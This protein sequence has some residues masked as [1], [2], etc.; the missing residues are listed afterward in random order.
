MKKHSTSTT[1]RAAL[2]ALFFTISVGLVVLAVNS[3]ILNDGA[4]GTLRAQGTS[5]SAPS[6][7]AAIPI[8]PKDTG[9][10]IGYENF[11][12]PGVLTPVKTTEAGQQVNSVEYLGRNAGE[13]SVGSNWATGV[14]NF[15][16]GLQT[17]FIT[18]DDSCPLT[19][20][21][22]N[23][24]NRAAPT[25]IAIDSDPIGFTDRGFTDALGAHSRVFAGELTLLS[26]NTVKIS[27]TDDDG[28]TWV[29]DQSGGI[30]S[31]V[32]HETIGGGAYH[33]L[34]PPRPPG[35]TYPNA[36]YYCSQD[37]ATALCARSDDGGLHYGPSVPI[38]SLVDCAG[39]HGHVKVAP[40]GTVYVP[41]R[42]C[43]TPSTSAVVVSQD[44]GVTWT[45]RPVG[46]ASVPSTP[47]SDDPA[48]GID[49]NGRVYFLFSYN[50]TVAGVATSDDFG[51]TWQ[52]FFD[53]GSEFG[54]K[55]IA[56][57][58]A[59]GGSA[60]RAAIAFYGSTTATGD[61]NSDTFTG[62]W[63][64]YVA[65]TFTGG[66]TWTTTDVTPNAPMQRSGLLRGGGANVTRNLLDFFD[67]T[68]DS[69]GR[70]LVGYV[71]GCEGGP[72]KQA[73]PTASGNAY[74]VTATIARESSGR[75]LLDG[76]DP[77]SL[78]SQPGMPSVNQVRIGPVVH[79]A[80]SEADTGNSAITGYQILRGTASGAEALLTTVVGT[81]TGGSFDDLTANDTTKTYYYKVL[82]VNAV[83]TSCGN[84]EIAA[85][86]LGDGC[87]GI[88]MHKN[89][90]THPEANA[91]TAT[92]A[93]LLIDYIAVGEP[94]SSPG[95]FMFKMKVND[96]TTVPPNSRWRITWNSAAAETYPS[97]SSDPTSGDPLYAQQFYVG[98]TTGPSGPP[99]FE[100]GTLA[101]AGVPAVFVI[102]ETKQGDALAGSNFSTDGTITIFVPK[103]AF[104][105]Q[106]PVPTEP[107]V[108]SILGAM[109]GRT[110]TGDSPGSPESKLE[111]SNTFVD[112]TF[113]KAQADNSYP[114]ATYIVTG[115]IACPSVVNNP[116]TAVLK[117]SPSAG[118]PPLT[119]QFDGTES[120]DPDF[121]DTI[122]TYT[123]H[124]GDGSPD[125]SGGSPVVQHTYTSGGTYTATLVVTDSR[126]AAS[127]NTAEQV[128][129]VT[130]ASPTPSP[131]PTATATATASPA[132]TATATASPTATATATASPTATA[133]ATA[134]PTA[135]ATATASPTATATATA[136]PVATATAT[137]TP[138]ATA[139]AT[140]TPAATATATPTTTASPT[141][142]NVQLVN[143]AGRVFAQSGDKVGIAGFIISGSGTKRI[144][145]RAIGSSLTVNGKMQDPFLEIHD[146][147]GNP[148]LTN[149][150]WR[151]TQEAE[152]QQTGLAPTDDR[153][154]AIVKRLPPGAYTAI[155]HS[156]DNSPGIGVI[157]LY[158][159]STS[160][161]SE[162]GNL[163]VRAD[164]Q[165]GDN[166]LFD[167]L[168][169][170]GGLPKR[171]LFRAMGPSIQVNGQPVP[172]A[173]Q[174]P[175]LELHGENGTL[176]AS[177][178]DWH[179][180][181]NN[182]AEIQATGLAPSD[183]RESAILM[184]LVPGNYTTIVRG[185]NGTTGIA[186]AEAYK[187]NN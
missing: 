76:K 69:D 89:D 176:L 45:V 19:G 108:G 88:V 95:N 91:G 72:C 13:P 70:V 58:A 114:P 23:W 47:A 178:D 66:Q 82:A 21:S 117:A 160:D 122:A 107:A 169:L 28:V 104:G 161:P 43:S 180:A 40:D 60:N 11:T 67:I 74:T 126:G 165:T 53:V 7:I 103:I 113:V 177:N 115:N 102:S 84:N 135:T 31:A 16:S 99:T 26:P 168:I 62:F 98:M 57:P 12:A 153:E 78:T 106:I 151:S 133:T 73:A 64:L 5:L 44:N 34:V 170:Q 27:H 141:P 130:G 61:S 1:G 146:D 32:D 52:N 33:A 121:S 8:A 87:T 172:G 85:P 184:P 37:I 68:I 75:R 17:L 166:V 51:A 46:N 187:L 83:G 109:G 155:I 152:I 164:V 167:G 116:P 162:L 86:Y 97:V 54:L 139:T 125:V 10:K 185:K 59:V 35:T 49:N 159:L 140:P 143:I 96:L 3:N 63:H 171:V 36:V 14:A 142:T 9:P 15:Q 127:Q 158:D 100:Y 6:A 30:A 79:L 20:L 124:F 65:H 131:T 71:D 105:P 22:S 25:S 90:A 132:A 18:F 134:S 110:L 94:A 92:P 112:H 182:V 93:S 24:V 157:Q 48:I 123:F 183:D 173:L 111:R 80:W 137:A 38:Y 42:D 50:G 29:P 4:S 144:M 149:D 39:L 175:T 55:Q 41:N 138:T 150:N 81:Q 56:F 2:S 163:S 174:N 147:K 128:I 181:P 129:T 148:P 119:V 101:D 179:D 120:T 77:V 156:A 186:L 118:A 145:A 136:S 154:S